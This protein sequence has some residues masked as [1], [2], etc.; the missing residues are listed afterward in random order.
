[1]PLYADRVQE[2]TT[3]TGTGTVTL[4][5][6]VVGFRA[7]QDALTV[8]D[9]VHYAINDGT[10]WEVGDGVLATSTTLTRE[11]VFASSNAG[12]LVNFAAG[13][14]TVYIDLPAAACANV[15]LTT[16]ISAR[17]VSQ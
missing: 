8:G 16:A 5:G 15:G 3:T 1:M 14:K 4:A 9:R 6:A 17:M 11:E 10:D 12:A 13:T 7:F 2:T